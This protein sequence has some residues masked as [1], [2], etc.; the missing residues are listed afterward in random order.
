MIVLGIN[1]S[2]D[3]AAAIVKDGVVVAASRE[4][5]FSRVK[6]DRAFP[7]RAID[8]CLET[9]GVALE[10]LDGIVPEHLAQAGRRRRIAH[11]DEGRSEA[12]HLL[13][14]GVDLAFTFTRTGN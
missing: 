14:H 9:A 3:A 11:G 5:R 13:R 4:E 10:D 2:N 12:P 1:H 8:F 6:H 7:H